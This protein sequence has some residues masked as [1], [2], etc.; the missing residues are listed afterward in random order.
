MFK[1][2][3]SY[4]LDAPAERIWPL[5]FDPSSLM[6]L[7]PGCEGL[8]EAGPNEYRGTLRIGIAAVAGRYDTHVSVVD[9]DEPTFC[10]MKGEVSGPTGAISGEA[11]FEL[12]PDAEQTVLIYT[13]K[14]LITGALGRLS[15]RFL[16]GVAG[17][18]IR[19]GLGKLNRRLQA[20][21]APENH[22]D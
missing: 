7:I 9:R 1:L 22:E 17:A 15:P 8:E 13:G 3:D 14:A 10:R 4:T 19:Q 16:E 5:I 21:P 2:R 18:L 12:Q 6:S 11:T 20:E